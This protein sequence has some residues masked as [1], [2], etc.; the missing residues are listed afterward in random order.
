MDK[1]RNA[2]KA[3]LFI[4]ISIALIVAVIVAI[5]GFDSFFE[6]IQRRTVT[7]TLTDNLSGLDKGDDVRI[8]GVK[9]G[10][11]THI[12]YVPEAGE[13]KPMLIVHFRIPKKYVLRQDTQINIES[14][15]TGAADLN[16]ASLGT[17][18][19]LPE[20]T[21][22][23]GKAGGIGA[24]LAKADDTIAAFKETSLA[25]TAVVKRVEAHIDPMVEKYNTAADRT[26][27][28][29]MAIRDMIGQSTKDWKGFMADL[30]VSTTTIKEKLPQLL[31][32]ARMVMVKLQGTID[33]ATI[34][35]EDVKKTVANTRDLTGSARGI[36]VSNRAKF[37]GIIA[38]LK[39]SSDNIKHATVELRRSP[40]RLLYK[41]NPGELDNLVLF[42]SAREFSE[43]A[44]DL[45]DAVQALRDAVNS[46]DVP[47]EDMQKKID[48]LDRSFN[49]FT[50]VEQKLWK[51]VK[52]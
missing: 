45:N 46:G 15:V 21:A 19:E 16:I 5:Q 38:G 25:A 22:I 24:L 44:N 47:A 48:L 13:R 9:I 37:D 33:N 2:F 52:E 51:N 30:H 1:Q 12:E 17:G 42:D 34:A 32:D 6:P 8:G 11:V 18:D 20:R 3:G 43:G 41:P 27:E 31:D 40:W 14:T 29:M 23:T 49:K 28:M 39:A 36:L 26:S 4:I 35:M 7:F 10:K 50:G